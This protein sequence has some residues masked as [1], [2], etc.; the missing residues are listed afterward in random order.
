MT[1]TK[2]IAT[3]AGLLLLAGCTAAAEDVTKAATPAYGP[4]WRHEQMVQAWQKGETP[5][6]M[7]AR[8]P[9]FGPRMMGQGVMGA[10]VGEDGKIDTSKLPPWCPLNQSPKVE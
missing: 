2:F 8:G 10:A 7:Q 9:G 1:T 6:M 5:P 3:L 4:G